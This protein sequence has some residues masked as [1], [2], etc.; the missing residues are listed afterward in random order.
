MSEL[1]IMRGRII[2]VGNNVAKLETELSMREKE[3]EEQLERLKAEFAIDEADKIQPL[4]E[5]K[6]V[7]IDELRKSINSGLDEIET[8]LGTKNETTI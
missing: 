3:R 5:E 6:V 8:I 1:E 4:L 7:K 2:E